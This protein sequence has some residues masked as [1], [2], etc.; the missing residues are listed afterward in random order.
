[1]EL[2]RFLSLSD[3]TNL[4]NSRSDPYLASSDILHRYGDIR[5]PEVDYTPIGSERNNNSKSAEDNEKEVTGKNNTKEPQNGNDDVDRA[6]N[7]VQN[8]YI[9]LLIKL[10]YIYIII[11]MKKVTLTIHI[12]VFL[13]D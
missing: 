6:P 9:I 4:M 10:D 7:T 5:V 3:F 11:C 12:F 8:F 13:F 1:M 2:S